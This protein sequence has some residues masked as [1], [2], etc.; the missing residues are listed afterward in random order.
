MN[1]RNKV[2]FG[3]LGFGIFGEK[4]LIPGFANSTKAKLMAITKTDHAMAKQ[5]AK[6]HGIPVENA[7]ENLNDFLA[8]E[9]MDA[10]FIATPNKFHM[11]H[12]LMA[13]KA[14]KHVLLEK[15]MGMNSQECEKMIQACEKA[16]V[17]FMIAH[18]MRFNDVVLQI[19]NMYDS[20]NLGDLVAMNAQFYY[21]GSRSARDWLF[22]AE[23]AG[24][25]PI[26]DLGVHLID[27]MRFIS[28]KEVQN[29]KFVKK[30]TMH[31]TVESKAHIIM[32]FEDDVTASIGVGFEGNYYTCL[33]AIGSNC[34]VN[35]P[36]FNRINREIPMQIYQ[37]LEITTQIVKNG[38][39]YAK[40]ID[41]F[42]NSVLEEREVPI[43]G[44]EGLVNQKL[45]DKLLS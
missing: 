38:N 26:A 14:G 16:E 39:C 18:C 7:Y 3:I 2:N 31:G 30:Q 43:S 19:K 35:A 12:T 24:G 9:D 42:A 15:P 40:E 25:G 21:D 5:E 8:I 37:N 32:E 29:V 36:F 20:G 44:S 17:K 23:I 41:A 4:R 22:D 33:E 10:V 6:Q 27:T 28:G 45:L 1:P 34:A 13:A 11:E